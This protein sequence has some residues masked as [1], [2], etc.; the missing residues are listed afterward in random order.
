METFSLKQVVRFPDGKCPG[1]TR[2][3]KDHVGRPPSTCLSILVWWWT[4][5]FEILDNRILID[6]LVLGTNS[7]SVSYSQGPYP[8]ALPLWIS[9]DPV[10]VRLNQL[11]V[12]QNCLSCFNVFFKKSKY[13]YSHFLEKFTY[14][15]FK[16]T[17]KSLQIAFFNRKCLVWTWTV[18]SHNKL[19][20]T[21]H[22]MSEV[23]FI[24][25]I[26]F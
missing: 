10:T 12:T 4:A 21:H 26:I 8:A 2:T 23:S 3:R 20:Q 11:I 18:L 15:Y 7:K 14:E 17:F 19:V 24:F 22:D 13:V 16:I 1:L 5:N 9:I 25:Q 6:L